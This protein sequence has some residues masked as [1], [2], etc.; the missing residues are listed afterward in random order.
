MKDPI[1]LVT[2]MERKALIEQ[3]K[4]DLEENIVQT[5]EKHEKPRKKRTAEQKIGRQKVHEIKTNK[6]YSQNERI[7]ENFAGS[8][9]VWSGL[10]RL[11]ILLRM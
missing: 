6:V 5:L 9:F 2:L 1:L 7:L 10:E 4:Q 8:E 11:I 3:D